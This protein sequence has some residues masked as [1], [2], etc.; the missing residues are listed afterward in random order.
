[1]A[2]V[3]NNRD[4]VALEANNLTIHLQVDL[5]DNKEVILVEVDLEDDQISDLEMDLVQCPEE[6]SSRLPWLEL[7]LE[8]SEAWSPTSSARLS[9]TPSTVHSITTTETTIGTSSTT[10]VNPVK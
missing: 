2:E 5:E 3:S 6:L 9:S 7:L 4:L 10:R 1:M 8:P